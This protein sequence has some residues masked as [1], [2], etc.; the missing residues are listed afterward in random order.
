MASDYCPICYGS[1][2]VR[3]V[4]PCMLCGATDLGLEDARQ[5]RQ[6]YHEF[7]ILDSLLLVLCNFCWLDFGSY[8]GAY[9]GLGNKRFDVGRFDKLRRIGNV[10]RKDK[11]C[12]ACQGRLCL[13]E[14]VVACRALHGDQQ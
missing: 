14:F 11:F 9:F 5:D 2:E 4:A 3:D 8:H 10:I 7:R 6:E 13:L 1:L 12:P